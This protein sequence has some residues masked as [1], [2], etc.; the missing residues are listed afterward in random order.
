[1]TQPNPCLQEIYSVPDTFEKVDITG[2][3]A[4]EGGL[5]LDQTV[6]VREVF[7]GDKGDR[8]EERSL[9]LL[10]VYCVPGVLHIPCLMYPATPV[11]H[12]FAL[13]KE[14]TKL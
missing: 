2:R 5:E 4:T 14:K 8:G 10:R 12:H 11:G 7:S 9:Y 6:L 3:H 1:M 13:F